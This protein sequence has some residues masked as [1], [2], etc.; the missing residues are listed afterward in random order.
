MDKIHHL[1]KH[2]IVVTE[3]QIFVEKMVELL[4]K[5]R[6]KEILDKYHLK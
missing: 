1:D 5:E 6:I 3:S 2:G 4:L